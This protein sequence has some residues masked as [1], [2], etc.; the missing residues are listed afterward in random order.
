MPTVVDLATL[1]TE[2]FAIIGENAGNS[3]GLD[4]S[5]AG[6]VNGD[7][8]D[9]VIIGT[10]TGLAYL[11]YGRATGLGDIDLENLQASEGFKISS[12]YWHNVG[13]VSAAGDVNGDGFDDVLVGGAFYYGWYG[14][15]D[16]AW[17]IFGTDQE[18]GPVNVSNMPSSRGCGIL[19]PYSGS[20]YG[21]SVGAA[22][23]VNGDGFDDFIIGS[24]YARGTDGDVYVVFGKSGGFTGLSLDN[25]GPGDGFKIMGRTGAHDYAGLS[26]SGAGDVN[27]DGFADIIIGAP[28]ADGGG[29]AFVIFGKASGLGTID[30]SSLAASTGF[31]IQGAAAGDY[32]GF[33]V[34]AAGDFNG[35]G[36]DDILVGVPDADNNHELAGEA[37]M[38][39]GK[40]SGFG[41]IDLSNLAAAAGFAIYGDDTADHAGFSVSAAGDVNNDGYDDIIIGAPENDNL[42]DG[43]RTIDA[44]EAYVIYGRASGFGTIDLTNLSSSDG[45]IIQGAAAYDRAG[46]SVSGAG[47]VD[48]DGFDDLIVGAPYNDRGAN[49][50][51]VA[52]IVSGQLDFADEARN[53]FNGDGHS[54]VLWRD[55]AGVL[56]EWLG[57]A[58]GTLAPNGIASYSIPVSLSVVASGDFN[59]D[60]RDD[61]L[62]RDGAG[63]LSEWLGQANGSFAWNADA[64]YHVPASLTLVATGDFNN[65]GRDDLLWRD[66]AGTMSEW[67][68]QATGSFA[69]NANAIYQVPASTALVGTGDFNDDGRADILWRD[70]AGNFSEW[71]GQTD[72]TFAWNSSAAHWLPTSWTLEDTGDFNGDGRDDVLWRDGAGNLSEWLGQ[73]NGSFAWN[74]L[75]NS[76]MSASWTLETTGD[77]NKDGRDDILWRDGSGTLSEW[78]GQANGTFAWNPDAV[79]SP[80]SSWQIQPDLL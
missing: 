24:P 12:S 55:A 28:Y 46:F 15:Y 62:W 80:P 14:V 30:L 69:W 33:S 8:L 72:G 49:N 50:A 76:Q 65:D 35:D 23:D 5:A 48:G 58:D 73:A 56:R 6:D 59:S 75:L 37:Y 64:T 21:P 3:A 71:L 79:Y 7:G 34:S 16:Q 1:D 22:G 32:A 61:I 36:F 74:P 13:D 42:R 20:S 39:F 63:T 77:F 11:V 18:V 78:L 19:G 10:G 40:A 9:D 57:Q 70:N 45:F 47:D 43:V 31:V 51:G 26:V 17:V 27:G 4:V 25:L 67:L 52:Y 38:I 54:D 60:G 41:T 68:G 2:A 29:Q 66:A 44:G 53:D